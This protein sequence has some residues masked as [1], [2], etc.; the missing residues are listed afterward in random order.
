M[1][2]LSNASDKHLVDYLCK[3]DNTVHLVPVQRLV[4]KPGQKPF[5]QTYWVQPHQVQSTDKMVTGAVIPEH[6]HKIQLNA[7]YLDDSTQHYQFIQ[8]NTTNPLIDKNTYVNEFVSSGIKT[9][10]QK[11]IEHIS[12][13]L[14]PSIQ[15]GVEQ[16]L[17]WEMDDVTLSDFNN[18]TDEEFKN[19]YTTSKQTWYNEFFV[20]LPDQTVITP[21]IDTINNETFQLGYTTNIP[22]DSLTAATKTIL[23]TV[24]GKSS[25]IQN[26]NGTV[27]IIV[28]ESIKSDWSYEDKMTIINQLIDSLHTDFVAHAES[29]YKATVENTT[30]TDIPITAREKNL[31]V[32]DILNAPA[33]A[34][35][36]YRAAGICTNPDDT[37]AQ[38]YIQ[39]LAISRHAAAGYSSKVSHE[40]YSL[41]L[42]SSFSEITD[43]LNRY[44]AD[45]DNYIGEIP[46]REI[47]SKIETADE[48]TTKTVIHQILSSWDM[49]NHKNLKPVI[50]NVFKVTSIPVEEKFQSIVQNNSKFNEQKSIQKNCQVDQFFHGTQNLAVS[51]ILGESGQFEI[52][53]ARFGRLLGDG[54]YVTNVASKSAQYIGDEFINS[55]MNNARGTL[56]IVEASLGKC[57]TTFGL[58]IVS[59][60]TYKVYDS[61]G[62]QAQKNMLVNNE[63][64]VF[65]NQAVKPTYLV[66]M[67]VEYTK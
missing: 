28:S 25:E 52:G 9:G 50:H 65:N 17:Y 63:W 55:S 35:K 64:C 49:V 53:E 58:P 27:K 12:N 29:S 21:H 7:K 51:L 23:T 30:V 42:N 61:I 37:T 31:F 16:A 41:I 11:Q 56:M 39:K 44:N 18:L 46:D 48:E 32:D 22:Y 54:V 19:K 8:F 43:I 2:F 60:E 57:H 20:N 13:E 36:H 15:R 59:D 40:D 47:K 3:S 4:N 1:Y 33:D 62:V 14:I 38:D 6:T 5:L 67:T 26:N 45:L 34:I 10:I 24:F 66:D